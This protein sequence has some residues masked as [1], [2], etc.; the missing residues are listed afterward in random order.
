MAGMA[1][2]AKRRMSDLITQKIKLPRAM[3]AVLGVGAYLK[4]SLCL[5]QGD[6]AWISR[7]NG[8]LDNVDAINAFQQT[9]QDMI[10]AADEKPVAIAHDW[11]PD[12]FCSRWAMENDLSSLG[13]QHHHAHIA[14]VMAEHQMEG[15]VLGLALDGFGLGENNEA[16][17]GE[18]LSVEGAAFARQGHLRVMKQPGG[19]LA[20]QQ[21]WRMGAA[22]LFSMGRGNE[23]ATRYADFKGAEHLSMLMARQ[24]NAPETTSAGRLF[25]AA[26]GLLG[27]MLEATFDGEAPMELERIA[28]QSNYQ[29]DVVSEDWVIKNGERLVLDMRPLLRKLCNAQTEEGAVLFHET[30]AAALLDWVQQAAQKT[31]IQEIVMSGGCFFNKILYKRLHD[32]MVRIGLKPYFPVTMQ[33]GDTAIALGQAYAAAQAIESEGE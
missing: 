30:F 24:L 4:N 23:I 25:D 2:G 1:R 21:P 20:A 11:H 22:A 15:A 9:A 6:E 5:I 18:L 29:P 13:V 8:S 3:P 33:S 27:V 31:G 19:D 26:C 28:S 17:G 7:E 16:W 10:D 14:A 32:G 12:F